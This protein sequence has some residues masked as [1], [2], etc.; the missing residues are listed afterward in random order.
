MTSRSRRALAALGRVPRRIVEAR[1]GVA[2]A[3][4]S[5]VL[6]VLSFPTFDLFPLAFV[7]LVPLIEATRRATMAGAVALGAWMGLV[8]NLGGFYWIINL[9]RDFAYLP[10]PI[11]IALW[12]LLCVQ[13][14]LVF[15]L[16]AGLARAMGRRGRVGALV[17]WPVGVVIADSLVPMIFKW[18]LGNSQYLNHALAQAAELGGVVLV[19]LLV[20]LSNAAV[21]TLWRRPALRRHAAF[22]LAVVGAA[23]VAGAVRLAAVDAATAEAETLRVGMVEAD[24]GIDDKGDPRRSALNLW[25]HHRLASEAVEEGAEL[26]VWPETAYEADEYWVVTG[27]VGDAGRAREVAS[28]TSWIPRN[29]TW[30]PS[31]ADPPGTT[32]N[33][34]LIEGIHGLNRVAPQR[35]H[36]VPLL[37][38]V[39]MLSRLTEAESAA[40]PPRG[41]RARTIRLHNAAV[42]LG[43]GGRILGTVDKSELMPFSEHVAF[44]YE[45]WRWT[46]INLYELIPSA[47]DF[48]QGEPAPPLI[49]PHDGDDVRVGVMICYEDILP[50]FGRAIARHQPDVLINVTNDA[51]FGKT[52]EPWLH[53]AL[54]TFRTIET[55]RA[56]VRS[57]NTGVSA[58]IDPAGRIVD[59]T[60]VHDAEVLVGDVPL[61]R[62]V[63]TP[64][65]MVGNWS[66]WLAGLLAVIVL[67]TGERRRRDA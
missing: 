27:D 35:G 32:A 41:G 50:R 51:W 65:M 14:G 8:A 37:T 53:L 64:Y 11:C 67:L 57:T 49:L 33:D 59:H 61:V 5:G 46:G 38:G 55:R 42:L 52:S 17:A 34:D 15:A 9:L 13:Q 36:D 24:I 40:A 4:L 16:A 26:L 60:S 44:G 63:R 29:A 10:I 19:S 1:A 43:E 28:R 31:S 2:L 48:Y 54:A 23:H 22:A 39:V 45:I 12:V 20:A 62:G 3:T 7:A 21:W 30:L 56:M 47:G 6:V 25:I 58:F 18:Y 66:G